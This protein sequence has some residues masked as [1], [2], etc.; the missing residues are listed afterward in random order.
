MDHARR[1]R[2]SRETRPAGRRR[3]TAQTVNR[4]RIGDRPSRRN[5]TLKAT[6]AEYAT[7]LGGRGRLG[8]PGPVP[9]ARPVSCSHLPIQEIRS[10]SS[11]RS[12]SL[13]TL[14]ASLVSRSPDTSPLADSSSPR[15]IYTPSTRNGIAQRESRGWRRRAPGS[16]PR[17]ARRSPG[18]LLAAALG[19]GGAP[20]GRSARLTATRIGAQHALPW[21]EC[22]ETHTHTTPGTT[23]G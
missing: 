1:G 7:R 13:L 17:L 12:P 18:T 6:P 23:P 9:R 22:P 3:P 10:R 5:E 19:G 20:Y 2:A 15:L 4:G 8:A 11:Y 16:R 21:D 14:R